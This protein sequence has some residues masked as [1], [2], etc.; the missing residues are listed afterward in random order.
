MEVRE[1][2]ARDAVPAQRCAV[3]RNAKYCTEDIP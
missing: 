1:D 3:K 2:D